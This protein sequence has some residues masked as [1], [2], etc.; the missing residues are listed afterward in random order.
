M[1][2]PKPVS[3]RADGHMVALTP[4]LGVVSIPDA[5]SKWSAE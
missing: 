1:V 4:Y 2:L 3:Q 5:T